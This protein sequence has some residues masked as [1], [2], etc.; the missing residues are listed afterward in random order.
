VPLLD[1]PAQRGSPAPSA[2]SRENVL[3]GAQVKQI[4]PF[5]SVD[6]ARELAS[7]H[8]S[9]QIEQ[10][11]GNGRRADPVNQ[12]EVGRIHHSCAVDSNLSW[13]GPPMRN[14][15]LDRRPARPEAHKRGGCPMA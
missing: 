14:G 9:S 5:A 1:R 12:G 11:P 4:P 7:G 6:R 13:M 10:S 8:S 15:Y 2:A 3:E